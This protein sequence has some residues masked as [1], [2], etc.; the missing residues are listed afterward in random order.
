MLSYVSG[1]TARFSP[2][3]LFLSLPNRLAT[4][5]RLTDVSCHKIFHFIIR[6]P[7]DFP[8]Y[9]SFPGC[10]ALAVLNRAEGAFFN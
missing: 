8:K 5:A 4:V 10:L 3:S 6:K 1:K 9:F 2:A 7:W